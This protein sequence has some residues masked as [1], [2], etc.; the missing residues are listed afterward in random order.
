M[1]VELRGF[2]GRWLS[3]S[4]AA[5]A[6][7]LGADADDVSFGDASNQWD[8]V[9]APNDSFLF[10]SDAC[11][12]D[13]NVSM[14]IE[15]DLERFEVTEPQFMRPTPKKSAVKPSV[16]SSETRALH[17][18]IK[19]TADEM[20]SKQVHRLISEVKQPWERGPLA[21]LFSKQKPI[22]ERLQRQ[23]RMPL[24]GLSDH[25]TASEASSSIPKPIQQSEVTVQRIRASRLVTSQDDYRHLALSRFKTMVLL[26][27]DCTRLGQSLRSF[28]GTLCPDDELSQIFMDVFAPKATG[29]ILKRCNALW[30]FSCWLQQQTNGSPFSQS[31]QVLYDYICHLRV[32]GAG[33]TTPSQL[34]EAMRFADTLLGFTHTKLQDMLSA[35]V[36]GAAHAVY[37]T[38]RIRKPAEVLTVAEVSELEY[39][40]ANDAELHRRVIAGHLLFSFAAAA[41]WHDSMYVVAMESSEAGDIMLLEASTSKHKSSRGKEQQMELLP[42]TA[43]GKLT[44]EGF[45]GSS[46]LEARNECNAPHWAHFLN[47]WSDSAHSWVNS[48]MSTAEATGWLR[49]FLEPSSGADRANRLTVHGLKATLLSWAAKSTLFGADEQLALGH[50]VHAQYRSAMIYSRDN[51]IGL[52]KKL[53]DMFTRI[54]DGLFD[55]DA[56]R[57]SRLFQLAYST[58][59]EDHGDDESGDSS[60]DSDVS[61]VAHSDGEHDSVAQRPNFK[62]L[63]ADDLEV[64]SCVINRNSKVIHMIAGEDEKFWCGRHPS[65]TFRKASV[66]DLSATEAVICASCSQAYRA[67]GRTIP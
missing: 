39:I 19:R 51:Q 9:D 31:E 17:E 44:L 54:R 60:A 21:S 38:K 46:W 5:S 27:M 35:R 6:A 63:E 28:A 20:A 13:D 26:D 24:V 7:D 50:H 64:E 1:V 15:P 10:G 3:S 11:D 29:T 25:I 62:R 65:S 4:A 34:V 23:N 53:H 42:F 32:S 48:R 55:P 8:T 30:R 61:S 40:C 41:R 12:F 66:E 45:W 49:E 22:W 2:R 58:M 56:T 37:M 57:V 43:L 36:T 33:A 18:S 67:S 16:A 47:S 52:C 14:D 59:L